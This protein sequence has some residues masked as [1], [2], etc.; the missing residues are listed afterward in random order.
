MLTKKNLLGS[1]PILNFSFYPG[2]FNIGDLS[3]CK[4]SCKQV[5]WPTSV[6]LQHAQLVFVV[7]NA[8]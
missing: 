8:C 7:C 4:L 6:S 1:D 2:N 3:V 5:S